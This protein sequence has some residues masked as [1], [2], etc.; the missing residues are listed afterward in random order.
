[1]V[2]LRTG[3]RLYVVDAVLTHNGRFHTYGR[4]AIHGYIL[5]SPGTASRTI[6][7][8]AGAE[9]CRTSTHCGAIILEKESV[10]TG[11]IVDVCVR[12]CP[13]TAPTLFEFASR[14]WP[15]V[16]VTGPRELVHVDQPIG[17][18]PGS[19]TTSHRFP[20]GC[21]VLRRERFVP[22]DGT[23]YFRSGLELGES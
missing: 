21:P 8:T 17:V 15:T 18:R 1:M 13:P 7:R 22:E 16:A 19:L 14:R 6:L 9:G 10:A 3:R 20:C 23:R 11:E 2:S 5:D 12:I 4:A